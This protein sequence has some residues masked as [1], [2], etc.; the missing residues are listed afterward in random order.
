MS[1]W[2]SQIFKHSSHISNLQDKKKLTILH[3]NICGLHTKTN[4]I[5]CNL[6]SDL[7]HIICLTKNHLS[8]LEIQYVH[9]DNYTISTYYYRNHVLKGAVFI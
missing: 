2:T 6:S 8:E 3:K 1:L 9:T 5:L 7:P 4:E